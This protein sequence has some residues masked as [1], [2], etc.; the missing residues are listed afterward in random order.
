M[1]EIMHSCRPCT[2]APELA[3]PPVPGDED[4]MSPGDDPGA[5]MEPAPVR[6]GMVLTEEAGRKPETATSMRKTRA[7]S[8]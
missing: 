6:E 8:P 4:R 7:R 1:C 5:G 3:S 2:H